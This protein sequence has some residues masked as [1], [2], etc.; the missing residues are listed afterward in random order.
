[1]S[2][3]RHVWCVGTIL[4][5][6]VS[7]RVVDLLPERSAA[8][9]A[10]WLAQHPTLTV[11]CRDRS[12]LY[13]EGIRQGVPDVAQVVD[14]FHLVEN[15]REAVEAFLK[16]QRIALDAAA[17]RTTQALTPPGSPVPVTPMY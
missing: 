10:A 2:G 12:P 13:A 1:M 7:H 14:R 5:D 17:V 8:A 6:L 16:N 9:M 15:F 11:V 4:V 3:L